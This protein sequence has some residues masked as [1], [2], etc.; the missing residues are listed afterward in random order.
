MHFMRKIHGGI[1]LNSIIVENPTERD[2]MRYLEDQ[3]YTA[4]LGYK[5]PVRSAEIIA[6]IGKENYTAKLLR[7]VFSAS[8]RFAQIDRKWDLEVR[9]EDVQKPV[10]RLLRQIM[11]SYGMP[12]TVEQIADELASIYDRAADYYE[13]MIERMVKNEEKYFSLPNGQHGL[14]SWTLE[15]TSD[16]EAD[17]VFDNGIDETSVQALAAAAAKI[18]WTSED[19]KAIV[20]T[21]IEAVNAPVDNKIIGLYKWR[22]IGDEFDPAA[23]FAELYADQD[24]V[25]LSD[26]RWVTRKL[27]G[28]YDNLLVLTADRLIDEIIE[29]AP[30][31]VIEKAEVAE[32]VAPTLSLTISDRDLDE[33]AQI[34]SVKGDSRMPLILESIFELS[35]RDPIYAV[36]AEGLSDAM[37]ADPRFAWVGADRW[38]MADTIPAYVYAIPQELT[39]NK[40][41]FET[42]EGEPIEI[43]LEEE[44][45][46]GGLEI[47]IHN[48]LV[49]D[50]GDQDRI[51]EQDK[52]PVMESVRCVV[53][54]HHKELG[55]FPLCQIPRSF[56]PLGPKVCELTLIDGEKRGDVWI[57]HETGLIYDMGAWYSEDMPESGAV[58]NLIKT[59]KPGEYQIVYQDNH[60]PLT[61]VSD[62][63]IEDLQALAEESKKRE[64]T[65]FELMDVI[66]NGHRK[67]V[68]Y[69]TLFTEVNIVRRSS[70]R[71]VASILSSYYAFYQRPKTAVWQ[72]DEK[73]VDQGFKKAKRKYVRK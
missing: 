3:A 54:K 7:H 62:G 39:I 61:F 40:F 21:F 16:A 38:R 8:T 12:M 10:E 49:Q 65:T 31:A 58:F 59:D 26:G 2:A 30:A 48:P 72:F 46:E 73:K 4:M 35:V 51:T 47:E 45:L 50:V 68:P 55:T 17:I 41:D 67:G 5:E 43:E 14:I 42:P 34:V 52:L 28:E 33:V 24:L 63:R 66:M 9:Y 13:P 18:D 64:M 32:D 1:E 60:D 20:E 27:A 6:A 19:F 44:G 37:R 29:E 71:L 53:T 70:R 69:V 57:N 22:A 25:W 36:A 56:L 11:A 23:A 15:I